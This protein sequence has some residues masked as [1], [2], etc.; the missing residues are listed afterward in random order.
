[1]SASLSDFEFKNG[2]TGGHKLLHSTITHYI[3]L[4]FISKMNW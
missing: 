1:M 3:E 4:F 2:L